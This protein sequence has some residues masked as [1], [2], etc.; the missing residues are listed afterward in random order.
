MYKD[1]SD[2]YDTIQS[3]LKS[4][5]HREESIYFLDIGEI[6]RLFH[7]WQQRFEGIHPYYAIKCNPDIGFIKRLAELGANFDCAS[8]A[9]IDR[10]LSLGISPD[11][12]IFANPCKRQRDIVTAYQKGVHIVTFDNETELIKIANVCPQMGAMLRI[13]AKDPD[14]RCQFAHKFGADASRWPLLFETAKTL[15]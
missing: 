15:D 3:F 1:E 14:A 2:V 11:R 6:E 9:E 8:I 7:L 12:I 10:V 5:H 4:T 13:Y